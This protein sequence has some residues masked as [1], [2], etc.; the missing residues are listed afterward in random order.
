M[1]TPQPPQAERS[2]PLSA[3]QV[4]V[5]AAACALAIATL[6]YNQPLLPLIGASF[7][8]GS[9]ATSQLVMLSQL[10]Y[11]CG[12]FLF[13]P[14]GDR[15]DRKRLILALL[16][17]NT[18][19]VAACAAAPSFTLL[20]IATFLTGVATVTPQIII[21]T[22]SGMA[23]PERLGRTV[24]ILLSGMSAG[25]L[26]G[27]TLSGFVGEAAGWRAVFVLAILINFVLM[28]IVWR[29]LPLTRP[30]TDMSYPRLLLSLWRLF[31]DQPML[32]AACATGFLA[33]ASFSVL[34]ATLASLL[35][36]PP[37]RY[38]ADVAGLFGLV[39]GFSIFTAQVIGRLTDRLGTRFMIAAG[40]VILVGAFA[41]VS[42]TERALWALV[43]GVAL[44]DIG[45]RSVLI[46]N[47]TRIYPLQPGSISRLN[48]VL[49]VSVFTGGAVGSTCGAAAAH[50]GWSGVA[51]TGI[52]L[53]TLGFI[54]H[55]ATSRP[56]STS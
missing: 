47:Q 21:P 28:T 17:A 15:L 51:L 19:G 2:S 5:M 44:I 54:F 46:P 43:I 36:Q 7:D 45:Y 50:W 6:Y 29:L 26:L 48:T 53:A 31:L 22:V 23:P 1:S 33:F 30:T 42:Q 35:A 55:L 40:G 20:A 3:S 11:A 13:V 32:R 49:M 37:Y 56:R 9:T 4:N 10:G 41:F 38:G 39:A 8:V 34:W 52:A 16:L 24:G 25:L 27:R 18:V 14:M 12:L